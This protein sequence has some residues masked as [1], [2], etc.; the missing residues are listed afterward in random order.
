[1]TESE[2][3]STSSLD[4]EWH[5]WGKYG[6]S[7]IKDSLKTQDETAKY[8]IGLISTVVALYTTLLTYFGLSGQSDISVYVIIPL[9]LMLSGLGVSL[10]V[11]KPETKSID[12]S[13]PVGIMIA[14]SERSR[15]KYYFLSAGIILFVLGIISIPLVLGMGTV[16]PSGKV[17]LLVVAEK[18]PILENIS[19][20]FEPGTMKTMP[21]ILEQEDQ[22]TYTVSL[23]NGDKTIISKD[24]VQAIVYLKG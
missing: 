4:D 3:T 9:L 20:A 1:M 16:H 18:K 14:V 6:H 17:Q 22:K 24:W 21:L 5:E 19:V 12:P 11:F 8:I 23:N 10:L 2:N 7:L 15:T 13:D